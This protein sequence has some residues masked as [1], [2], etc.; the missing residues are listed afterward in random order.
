MRFLSKIS[1]LLF[2]LIAM[3]IALKNVQN[4]KYQGFTDDNNLVYMYLDLTMYVMIAFVFVT[5]LH[6]LITYNDTAEKDAFVPTVFITICTVVVSVYT[7][8]IYETDIEKSNK[9]LIVADIQTLIEMPST[10]QQDANLLNSYW[11]SKD[12]DEVI[13]VIYHYD[14]QGNEEVFTRN[15]SFSKPVEVNPYTL[16]FIDDLGHLQ[17]ERTGKKEEA[18]IR[19][20]NADTLVGVKNI[21][22]GIA[23]QSFRTIQRD[24]AMF[25]LERISKEQFQ[26][27]QQE[28][29]EELAA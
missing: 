25:R 17:S 21:S 22:T 5:F 24:T 12:R 13:S 9:A 23:K 2:P 4:R 19:F 11:A 28:A 7:L 3:Q 6:N 14:G 10:V 1:F 29:E 16:S 20:E 26:H 18:F 8:F 27:S 15:T